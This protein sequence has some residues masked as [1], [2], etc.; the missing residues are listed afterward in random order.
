VLLHLNCM[1]LAAVS[2]RSLPWYSCTFSMKEVRNPPFGHAPPLPQVPHLTMLKNTFKQLQY[3]ALLFILN[4][5]P[6]L[7]YER[8]IQFPCSHCKWV[9]CHS[10]Q[11]CLVPLECR[12]P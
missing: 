8:E 4:I 12:I 5:S 10:C 2:V 1:S 11:Y 6:S 3:D 7:T 9:E